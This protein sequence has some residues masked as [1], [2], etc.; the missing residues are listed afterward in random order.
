MH[1]HYS[2]NV[3]STTRT[4][5]F[6]RERMLIIGETGS[7]KTR[8]QFSVLKRVLASTDKGVHFLSFD[9]GAERFLTKEIL[10]NPQFHYYDAYDWVSS[11]DQSRKIQSE[12]GEGDF[13]F[14]D[15][16]DMLWEHIQAY[17]AAA[18][19]DVEEKD[20]DEVILQRRLSDLERVAQLERKGDADSVKEAKST[21]QAI[22]NLEFAN[23]DWR[24]MKSALDDVLYQFSNGYSARKNRISLFATALAMPI[25]QLDPRALQK[26][27]PR[28][29]TAFG[30][31]VQGE[32]KIE[33]YFDTTVVLKYDKGKY[34]AATKKDRE[35]DLFGWTEVTD[36]CDT[37][38]D[39]TGVNLVE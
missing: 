32:K 3:Q 10:D 13:V 1:L 19:W 11:R 20:L 14:P 36:F 15:R 24:V 6:M 28:N 30:L 27:D 35:R 22:N 18:K 4:G 38:F 16:T 2:G 26:P 17:F 12:W 9:D 39:Q 23:L 5:E 37:Y 29:L 7:G 31:Q 33:S 8:T 25:D 21:K 34:L